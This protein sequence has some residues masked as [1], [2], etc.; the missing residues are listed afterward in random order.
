MPQYLTNLDQ[1]TLTSKMNLTFEPANPTFGPA[2]QKQKF[3]IY[4]VSSLDVRAIHV[5]IV[6]SLGSKFK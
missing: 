2:K 3:E 1:A 5:G 6:A 4:D